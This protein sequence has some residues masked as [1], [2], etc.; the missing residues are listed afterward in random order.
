ME[1]E[2]GRR[3]RV[4]EGKD[5]EKIRRKEKNGGMATAEETRKLFSLP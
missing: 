1:E 2:Q 3:E 4:R 5:K